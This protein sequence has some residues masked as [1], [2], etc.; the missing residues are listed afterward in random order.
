MLH[1][2]TETSIFLSL[3]NGCFC[4]MTGQ[5]IVH[6]KLVVEEPRRLIFPTN[7]S[8]KR[9]APMETDEERPKKRRKLDNGSGKARK[10]GTLYT[11]STCE[12]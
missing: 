7:V 6:R 11:L 2:L 3:P 10:A 9:K 12:K 8:R 5:P 1:L 4:Q